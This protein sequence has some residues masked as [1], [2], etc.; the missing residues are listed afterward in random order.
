[1]LLLIG[2]VLSLQF[3]GSFERRHNSISVAEQK[4]MLASLGMSS[5]DELIDKTVPASIRRKARTAAVDT[6]LC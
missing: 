3:G 4:Q 6:R 2:P 1:M 5:M